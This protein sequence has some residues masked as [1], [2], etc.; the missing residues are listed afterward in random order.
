LRIE[1][2]NGSTSILYRIWRSAAKEWPFEADL[3]EKQFVSKFIDNPIANRKGCFIALQRNKPVGVAFI[4]C[5][6]ARKMATIHLWLPIKANN[7]K[8]RQSL[9]DK[10]ISW[11]E[12]QPD[13]ELAYAQTIAFCSENSIFFK[14]MG[15]HPH[16]EF[17]SGF[18]MKKEIV[19]I[20]DSTKYRDGFRIRRVEDI[21][22][23]DRIEQ[24]ARLDQIEA[25]SIGN[26]F[27]LKALVREIKSRVVDLLGYCY[28]IAI[29]EDKVVGY[30]LNSLLQSVSGEFQLRNQ[31]IIVSQQ[32]RNKGIGKALLEDGLRWGHE[33]GAKVAYIS[34]HSKNPARFLYERVGYKIVETV[35]LLIKEIE[36][37]ASVDPQIENSIVITP[38]QKER[39]TRILRT[40]FRK[41]D[42]KMAKIIQAI[43]SRNEP[44][45]PPYWLSFEMIERYKV[46]THAEIVEGMDVLEIGCGAHAIST[47]PLAHLVGD[48]GRVV[49]IDIERWT[50]FNKIVHHT[51]LEKRINPVKSNATRL[52]FPKKSFDLAVIVHGIRSMRDETTIISILREM[53][54]VSNQGFI[55]ESLPI[56]HTRAQSA[57]IEMY[58]LRQ[59]IF[60]GISGKMDDI[61]YLPM[62]KLKELI[63]RASGQVTMAETLKI[64]MPHYLAYI[65][66]EYIRKV[67]NEK[68]REK[69]LIRWDR[70]NQKLRR[71][72]EEHPPVALLKFRTKVQ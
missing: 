22:H 30:S 48:K 14:A 29:I 54:R 39:D 47:I 15:F 42:P 68:K 38:K 50:D 70:A 27:K 46:L 2:Y 20:P 37:R 71:C 58:N 56:A 3:S 8:T 61:H 18:L 32:Q 33:K 17:P 9:L 31:G 1:E 63:V 11:L 12:S 69:L 65:P 28:S 40:E 24:M 21:K 23:F 26:K 25:G 44:H 43:P 57:H 16:L 34:T 35:E 10:G 64:K 41:M 53:M 59:E 4:A 13:I 7:Y 67:K 66:R 19:A 60:E 49:A 5:V 6:P 55:A 62:T 51:G 72:G 52:P 45:L 36:H